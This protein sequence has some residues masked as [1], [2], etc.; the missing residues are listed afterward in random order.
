MEYDI[1]SYLSTDDV[2]E[3]EVDKIAFWESRGWQIMRIWSCD[4][5][6]SMQNVVSEICARAEANRAQDTLPLKV[7]L[8]ALSDLSVRSEIG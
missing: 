3:R 8:P 7:R 6:L 2:E 4:R 5:W 1:R